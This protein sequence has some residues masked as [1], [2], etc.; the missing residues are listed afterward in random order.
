MKDKTIHPFATK[1]YPTLFNMSPDSKVSIVGNSGLMLSKKWGDEINKSDVVVRFN[2]APTT[3]FTDYVGSKTTLRIVN[4]HC[5]GGVTDTTR[6]PS[7]SADFLPSL[8]TQDILCKTFN[9]EEFYKGIMNNLNKHRIYFLSN[10]FM[11]DISKYTPGQEPTAGLVGLFLLLPF[12]NQVNMYGFTFWD[13]SYDYHYFEEV[14]LSADKLGHSFNRER[15]IVK[16]LQSEKRII[17][18]K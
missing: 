15:E 6:N 11:K 14:P 17:I 2:H 4:G 8:P 10:E 9:M 13:N 18:H 5:F 7:A 12:F 1:T 3:G 16:Q